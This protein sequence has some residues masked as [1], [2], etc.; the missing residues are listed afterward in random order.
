MLFALFMRELRTRLGGRWLGM[1]WLVGEPLAHVLLM[2]AIFTYVRNVS[3]RH[4]DFPLFLVTGLLPFFMFRNLSL[5]LADAIASNRGLF[6]YRQVK[7]IDT[8][9]ARA[10]VETVLHSAVYAAALLLLAWWGLPALPHAPLE[11]MLASIN[12]VMLGL[13]IGLVLAVACHGRPRLRAAVGLVFLPLYLAS[14]VIFSIE[15]TPPDVRAW[16]MLN[17]VAHLIDLSRT[18]FIAGHFRMAETSMAYSAAWAL[19]A[20]AL[21]LSLYRVDRHR[22]ITR[23]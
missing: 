21:G 17:P 1:L 9:V 15:S 18:F 23:D 14:G 3:A 19:A 2:L 20:T 8:L 13:G 5:R 12:L 11:L 6:S 4:T 16:L 10:S 22:L 7:P